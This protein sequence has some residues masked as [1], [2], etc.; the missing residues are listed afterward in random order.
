MSW[1]LETLQKKLRKGL[2]TVGDETGNGRGF[3]SCELDLQGWEI[4]HGQK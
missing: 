3:Y 4:C 1:I 2:G